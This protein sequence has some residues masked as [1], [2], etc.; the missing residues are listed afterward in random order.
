MRC[1]AGDTDL[2]LR[3][4]PVEEVGITSYALRWW[5]VSAET[6]LS[7]ANE[8]P[9]IRGQQV[10]REIMHNMLLSVLLNMYSCGL[11]KIYAISSIA[12]SLQGRPLAVS[13]RPVKESHR[14]CP[15]FT[16]RF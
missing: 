2:F 9:G 11:T 15:F 1:I 7:L 3:K 8:N 5:S 4:F 10:Q 6:D 13:V 12:L 14:I 16:G